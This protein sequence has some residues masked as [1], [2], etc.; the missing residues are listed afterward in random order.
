MF[1]R[2]EK[3]QFALLEGTLALL[4]LHTLRLGK[5]HGQGIARVLGPEAQEG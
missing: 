5:E 3:A 1:T 2:T 4:I